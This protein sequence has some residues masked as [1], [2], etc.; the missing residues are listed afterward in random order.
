ML[1][2]WA[3][4]SSSQGDTEGSDTLVSLS[5]TGLAASELK[6]PQPPGGSL[7]RI[8]A[9][10]KWQGPHRLLRHPDTWTRTFPSPLTF[11]LPA[12]ARALLDPI[13]T[14]VVPNTLSLTKELTL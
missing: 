2:Q 7:V 3:H 13:F 8:R 9:L 14:N 4:E 5:R 11:F 10:P 6:V 12:A 1:F